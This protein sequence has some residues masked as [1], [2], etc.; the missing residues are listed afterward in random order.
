[1]TGYPTQSD[2]RFIRMKTRGGAVF[3]CKRDVQTVDLPGDEPAGIGAVLVVLGA[4][5]LITTAANDDDAPGE[6]GSFCSACGALVLAGGGALFFTG[7]GRWL[8]AD[9]ALDLGSPP[10]PACDPEA[11]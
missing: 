5:M 3:V 7:L 11:P 6:S 9:D 4:V 8:Q 1:M 2:R 10:H